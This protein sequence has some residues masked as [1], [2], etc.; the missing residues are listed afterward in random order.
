MAQVRIQEAA[1]WRL[2]EIYLYTREHWGEAQAERYI[3]GL[4]DS[5]DLIETHG[6]NSRPV[7]AVF[8]VQGFFY[9][10]GK[11]FVYWRRLS[12]EDIGIVTILHERMHQIERLHDDFFGAPP[13]DNEGQL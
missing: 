5:F 6:I 3:K 4:F 2:D 13:P 9:R 12:N 7:P 11:H 8:N 1:S 10:Y